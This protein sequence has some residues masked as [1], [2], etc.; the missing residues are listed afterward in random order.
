MW[1]HD[2]DCGFCG[3]EARRTQSSGRSSDALSRTR[4]EER[5]DEACCLRVGYWQAKGRDGREMG[6]PTY[7]SPSR[8]DSL[9]FPGQSRNHALARQAN[10]GVGMGNGEWGIGEAGQRNS[11]GLRCDGTMTASRPSQ[12]GPQPRFLAAPAAP[13]ILRKQTPRPPAPRIAPCR[14]RC[15]NTVQWYSNGQRYGRRPARPNSAGTAMRLGAGCASPY[16]IPLPQPAR[17]S[18]VLYLPSLALL[19][20]ARLL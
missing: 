6:L 2:S 20:S 12:P 16:L 1:N 19:I 8:L 5:R 3:R 9:H 11:R 4:R 10:G 7:L 17:K 14:A 18:A 15:S 13:L